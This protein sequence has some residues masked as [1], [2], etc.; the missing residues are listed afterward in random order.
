LIPPR[1][2]RYF[3]D[4]PEFVGKIVLRERMLRERIVWFQRRDGIR[5]APTSATRSS[6]AKRASSAAHPVVVICA[7]ELAAFKISAVT[8]SVPKS[9]RAARSGVEPVMC[10]WTKLAPALNKYVLGRA[11]LMLAS[12]SLPMPFLRK[13]A[14]PGEVE[15]LCPGAFVEAQSAPWPGSAHRNR[16][17]A[18]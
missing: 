11:F 1:R 13:S 2:A 18:S 7:G 15:A 3:G 16:A 6:I 5:E 9:S 4:C 12:S 17:R 10:P 14:R 8:G